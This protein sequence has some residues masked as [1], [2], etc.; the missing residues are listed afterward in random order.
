MALLTNVLCVE[1][2]LGGSR[3][4]RLPRCA[5]AA[6][7]RDSCGTH[8]TDHARAQHHRH[9][10]GPAD[11]VLDYDDFDN[12]HYDHDHYATTEALARGR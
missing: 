7:T 3:T 1:S 12:D 11:Y 9:E 8:Y 10:H 5:R 4:G 2:Q 6:P